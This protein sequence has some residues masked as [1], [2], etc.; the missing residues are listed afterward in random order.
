MTTVR[1]LRTTMGGYEFINL[2]SVLF[3]SFIGKFDIS[4]Q[5]D[6]VATTF[7]VKD[8]DGNVVPYVAASLEVF[9]GGVL[10]NDF[11]EPTTSNP[12][13]AEDNPAAGTF[14][15]IPAPTTAQGK[16][17]VRVIRA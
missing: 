2:D 8:A 3:A 17:R 15:L 11:I 5:V 13:M 14:T 4:D 12:Y 7:E 16:L 1:L 9:L 6:G 10:Q